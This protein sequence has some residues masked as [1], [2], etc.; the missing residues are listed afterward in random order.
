MRAKVVVVVLILLTDSLQLGLRK[1]DDIGRAFFVCLAGFVVWLAAAEML[2]L[3]E[4]F[5]V[6]KR[7][8]QGLA[9]LLFSVGAAFPSR[10]TASVVGLLVLTLAIFAL[11][12]V[13]ARLA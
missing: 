11:A 2:L 5:L 10:R 6:A 1:W 9:L 7:A 8:N 13:R 4:P 12:T 3:E